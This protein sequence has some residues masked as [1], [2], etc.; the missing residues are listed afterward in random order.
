[1][2]P[3]AR[4]ILFSGGGTVGHLAPGFALAEV[5]EAR[6]VTCVFATPGEAVERDWFEGR[7]PP[8]TLPAVR[9]PRRPLDA[10]RFAFRFRRC[11]GR[12]RRLMAELAPAAVVALGGWPCA[13]A[14][15]A[16]RGAG[17]P[18]VFLVPDA[19]PG[20]VVRKFAR[21]ADR[22][23]LADPRAEAHLGRHPGARVTGPLLRRAAL[24]V[25][26]D[27]AAF[28]LEPDRRT[29]FVTGGSLGALGLYE[30][31]LAGLEHAVAAEDGLAA[32]IQVLHAIGNTTVDAGA[33]YRRLGVAHTVVPFVH[34]MGAA[35]GT[36]DLVLCRAGASTCA[37]LQATAT[38]SVLV[39]Y[40]HHAD[41]QQF[42]NAEALV[43][44]GGARQMAE[45][46][47]SPE[48]VAEDVLGLLEDAQALRSM[49]AALGDGA[50]DGAA[51]VAD[52]L[53]R[54]LGWAT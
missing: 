19:V 46:E 18:L 44:L 17:V 21:R 10:L 28:G 32:R 20:M 13:P 45:D 12:A 15:W 16:A 14:A 27:A 5:L 4:T 25:R 41:R 53:D 51:A 49:R 8:R 3:T 2:T 1:M 42:H 39:P 22:I 37:E 50:Q 23:Y 29:L 35:Y 36:A 40:P 34:D 54:F 33:V 7:Q 52:D 38:P 11:V 9:L 43:A 30:R 48:R 31:F 24:D 6:G 26:R 47:L